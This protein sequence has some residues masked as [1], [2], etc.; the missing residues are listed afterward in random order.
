[1]RF[2]SGCDILLLTPEWQLQIVVRGR[3]ASVSEILTVCYWFASSA[4]EG[5]R[6]MLEA[7]PC[8]PAVPPD[9]ATSSRTHLP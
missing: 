6:L 3:V 8:Y 7:K 9:T 1:M 2:T 5:T 4:V